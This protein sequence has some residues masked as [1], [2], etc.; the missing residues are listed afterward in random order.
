MKR[1][2]CFIQAIVLTL[3]FSLQVVASER[4][5]DRRDIWLVNRFEAMLCAFGDS[6]AAIRQT[7]GEPMEMQEERVFDGEG[8]TRFYLRRV[9]RY[10]G[11]EIEEIEVP[12]R[13]FDNPKSFDQAEQRWISRLVCSDDR[14]DI[15]GVRVGMP[16][17][18]IA[19]VWGQPNNEQR[20]L[21]GLNDLSY[22]PAD[23]HDR[24]IGASFYERDGCVEIIEVSCN[25]QPYPEARTFLDSN[26]I[27]G[28]MYSLGSTPEKVGERLGPP[29]ATYS[30][31]DFFDGDSYGGGTRAVRR[32]VLYDGLEIDFYHVV[33][34]GIDIGEVSEK[35][36]IERLVCSSDRY[37]LQNVRIGDPV[38][39]AA[40]ELGDPQRQTER[41]IGYSPLLP[42]GYL[43]AAFR[44]DETGRIEG[45]DIEYVA[46]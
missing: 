36:W 7:L 33:F 16:L 30:E 11:L 42:S 28:M 12:A 24:Y 6:V 41:E 45:I 8:E 23:V 14:Y 18:T 10:K 17:S 39:K 35:I 19:S 43:Y 34:L 2:L 27:W 3:A 21:S 20:L 22:H 46:D 31:E 32:R 25:V 38:E 4:E 37:P 40:R 5:S 26:Y 44:F 13:Y 1:V 9:V 15:G 29:L